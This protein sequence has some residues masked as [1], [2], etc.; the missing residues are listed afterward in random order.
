[1]KKDMFNQL[2]SFLDRL[3][4]AHIAH[5][6]HDSRDDGITVFIDVPG[7]RWEVDFLDDG[8][9]DVEIFKGEGKILKEAALEDLF[10]RFSD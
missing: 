10:K 8:S 1:M 3:K 7:E 6:L 2:M 9:I 5:R 4:K